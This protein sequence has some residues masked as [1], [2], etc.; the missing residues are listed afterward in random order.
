MNK[1]LKITL[2]VITAAV[3]TAAAG[4]SAFYF[5]SPKGQSRDEIEV[6]PADNQYLD[7]EEKNIADCTPLESLFILAAN[8]NKTNSYR[9]VVTGE[10]DAGI[11]KQTVSGAKYKSGADA[12]YISRSESLFVN[13]ENKFFI[14]NDSVLVVDMNKNTTERFTLKEYLE[15]YGTDF[16]EVSNYELNENTITSA[17][18]VSAADGVYVYRYEIDVET[19]VNAYRVNMYKVGGL[20]DLPTFKKSTL[21]VAITENFMPVYITQT[22]EYT[23][24]KVF[25]ADCK[26][27]LTERFEVI[28]GET[29]IPELETL[30]S[31]LN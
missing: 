20:N 3:V 15:E 11:T 12:L 7:G 24:R 9:A 26:A 6:N 28:D 29:E 1:A 14:E 17:E 2:I 31:Q 25:S 8:L 30:R 16:R 22:D 13:T 10:V 21:E 18:L 23:A 19:G 4:F 27:V 5:L